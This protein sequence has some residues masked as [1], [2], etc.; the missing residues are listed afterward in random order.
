MNEIAEQNLISWTVSRCLKNFRLLLT[1]Y[2]N[3]T[4]SLEASHQKLG[5]CSGH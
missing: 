1:E 5:S 3:G 4:K 2:S